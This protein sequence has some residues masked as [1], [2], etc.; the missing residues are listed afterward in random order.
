M[1][2][3]TGRWAAALSVAAMMG[4]AA[5]AQAAEQRP[6]PAFNVVSL[7]G[8]PV[9]SGQIGG[10]GQ[11]LVVY[12]TPTSP[13]SVRLLSAMKAWESPAM[14]QRVVVLVGAPLDAAKAFVAARSQEF[15]GLRWYADPTNEAWR[16]LRLTGTPYLLGIRDARIM[17]SLA[18][19]LNDPAALE[20][21]IRS[22]LM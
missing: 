13:A 16:A 11:W 8:V 7:E 5:A 1:T 6:L 18:G 17:W 9:S 4:A 21:V 3:R 10:A 15:P 20:S 19:V 12:V 2:T 14:A 22:W